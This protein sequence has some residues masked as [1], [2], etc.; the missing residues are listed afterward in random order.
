M[1]ARL[2]QQERGQ[3]FRI[4]D[5]AYLPEKPSFPNPGLFALGG[6]LAGL[7]LGIGFC[8]AVD[9]L[10]PTFKDADEVV[11]TLDYPVLAVLPY[12]KVKEQRRLAGGRAGKS[13]R[14][15]KAASS[16]APSEPGAEPSGEPSW[17]PEGAPVEEPPSAQQVMVFS[18]R[19]FGD[20][21]DET[22]GRGK[23]DR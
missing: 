4:L 21:A 22:R 17:W 19:R 9:Y 20:E 23:G 13:K 2:E 15:A 16:D 8:I 5:P 1:A 14:A 11:A 3:Q 7:I 10:D 6:A 12:I 18:P